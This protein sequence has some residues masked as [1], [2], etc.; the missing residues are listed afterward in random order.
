MT[1]EQ[2][3]RAHTARPFQP[4]TLHCADGRQIQVPHPEFLA[5]SPSA[6]TI[7]VTDAAGVFE[8][9]DL[10]LVT[11]IEFYSTAETTT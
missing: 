11:S 3:H 2:L 6:R 7:G 9:I 8:I 4:F 5:A 1:I 10:L